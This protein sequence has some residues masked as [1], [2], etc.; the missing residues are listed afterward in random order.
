[1]AEKIIVNR[2]STISTLPPSVNPS[3][4]VEYEV[5]QYHSDMPSAVNKRY[6]IPLSEQSKSVR[7]QL[8]SVGDFTL[9]DGNDDG[10]DMSL[11]RRGLDLSERQQKL[12]EMVQ[13]IRDKAEN[14][15]HDYEIAKRLQKP[16]RSEVDNAAD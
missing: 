14:I 4:I 9:K 5:P 7:G 12:G 8:P 1:M 16:K 15:Q 11:R 6:F 3:E 13:D 10:R 2:Y